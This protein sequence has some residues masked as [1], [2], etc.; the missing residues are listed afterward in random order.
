[1]NCVFGS[2]SSTGETLNAP[3][4]EV[5][6]LSPAKI[7]L[8]LHVTGQRADGYHLLQ[9]W[10]QYLD[11][12]D[13]MTFRVHRQGQICRHDA[14]PYSLPEEDL[15][16]RAANLLK[17]SAA[18]TELG[19]EI[20]LE[21]NIPPGTGLGGGSSNAATTLMVLNRLWNLHLPHANLLEMG[22]QLGADVPIFL[23]GVASWVEGIGD[24]LTAEPAPTG[25]ILLAVPNATVSTARIFQDP[26][27]YR[28]H[29]T[30][31][32]RDY[33]N[34][35]TGN[36]LEAVTFRQFPA[37]ANLH[38]WLSGFG[39]ARM[40]GSGCA[41][42]VPVSSRSEAEQIRQQLPKDITSVIAQRLNQSPVRQW[43]LDR[44]SSAGRSAAGTRDC[45]RTT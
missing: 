26:A 33:D 29:P 40:S 11:W 24:Q 31:T 5:R 9:S 39:P 41:V 12:G 20:T 18:R 27:L 34:G 28:A 17:A 16:I 14:H 10:M 4:S 42:F 32:R 15:C 13:Q 21:K 2:F 36:D 38:Q 8:F 44:T 23:D 1:M 25:W 30:V 43:V 22:T 37:V 7:N 3:N 35:L 6:L 19:V 45:D